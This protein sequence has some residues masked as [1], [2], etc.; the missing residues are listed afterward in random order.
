MLS[1]ESSGI[2]NAN[3]LKQ[4]EE[5]PLL[6]VSTIFLSLVG[7]SLGIV[8]FGTGA[9]FFEQTKA[10]VIS[11]TNITSMDRITPLYLLL[12]AGFSLLSLVATIKMKHWQRTGFFFY[13]GAQLAMLFLP[14]IWLDWNAF[15]VVNSIFTALYVLIYFSF[16][17][18]MV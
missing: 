1:S 7:G 18:R 10:W 3:S 6:F 15:S 4:R 5:Q 2:M 17:N 8:L 12:F 13:T 11:V 16:Y 9:L 14:V